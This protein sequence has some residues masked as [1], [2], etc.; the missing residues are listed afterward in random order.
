MRTL[1][2]MDD[3]HLQDLGLKRH[4]VLQALRS[5]LHADPSLA[6][7]TLA[8]QRQEYLNSCQGDCP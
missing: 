8:R 1:L 4:E 7:A 3:H 6:L 5:P 2:E